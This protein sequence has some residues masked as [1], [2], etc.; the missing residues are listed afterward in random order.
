MTKKDSKTLPMPL[1]LIIM[2]KEQRKK[3][4]ITDLLGLKVIVEPL[5]STKGSGQ[6]YR[7]Q[8]FGHAQTMC[9]APQRCV[10]CRG[11]TWHT[12]ALKRPQNRQM[13]EFSRAT[14]C[15][16]RRMPNES[17]EQITNKDETEAVRLDKQ[18]YESEASERSGVEF[19]ADTS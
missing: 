17:E 4:D 13:R 2:S 6:C 1:V 11:L 19:S 8:L 5:R 14:S 18:K 3:Y 10:R 12:H 9:R 7:C 15:K 16:L